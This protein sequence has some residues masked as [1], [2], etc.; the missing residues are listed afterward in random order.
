MA[1]ASYAVGRFDRHTSD[2][3]RA[4][5]SRLS[6]AVDDQKLVLGSSSGQ[7]TFADANSPDRS[8]SN[9]SSMRNGRDC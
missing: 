7:Q 8:L 1:T 9:I 3:F 5:T 4:I 6:L 2:K